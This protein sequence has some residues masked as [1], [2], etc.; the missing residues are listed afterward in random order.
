MADNIEFKVSSSKNTPIIIQEAGPLEVNVQSSPKEDVKMSKGEMKLQILS[1]VA[2]AKGDSMYDIAVKHGYT[3]TEEEFINEFMAGGSG[4][5]FYNLDNEHPITGG[6]YTLD[7]AVEV[8]SSD[9]SITDETKNGMI[10]TFWDGGEWKTYRYKLFYDPAQPS[11]FANVDNWEEFKGSGG[12]GEETGRIILRR[13]S[14]NMTTKVGSPVHIKF[15]YDHVT[16]TGEE[17]QSTGNAGIAKIIINR[18]GYTQTLNRTL[19]AGSHSDIDITRYMGIGVTSVRLQVTVDTGLAQ[20]SAAL[21]WT[22]SEVALNLTSDSLSGYT[23]VEQGTNLEVAYTLESGSADTKAVILYLDGVQYAQNTVATSVGSGLFNVD[24]TE[25]AHGQ[26][27]IQLRAQQATGE[28]DEYEQPVLLYSNLIYTVIGVYTQAGTTPL[29]TMKVDIADGSHVFGQ[30]EPLSLNLN[31]Y[32]TLTFSYG[33]RSY[34]NISTEV[35]IKEGEDTIA[36]ATNNRESVDYSVRVLTSGSHSYSVNAGETAQIAIGVTATEVDLGV[37]VPSGRTM[38]LDAI[39][40]GHSNTDANRNTWTNTEGGVQT[41]TVMTDFAWSGD[42]WI[43]GALRLKGDAR[44]EVSYRPLQATASGGMVCGFKYKCTDVEEGSEDEK[45]ISCLDSNGTGFF[46]TPNE[47]TIQQNGTVRT[48][49]K[50][51][52][53][54]VY[55]VA[56]VVWPASGSSSDARKNARFI[57]IFIDGISSGGYRLAEGSTMFQPTSVPISIGANGVTTDIYRLW[58]YSRALNDSEVL[59]TFILDQDDNIDK[60]LE[61]R[62]DNA[63][64][65]ATGNVTPD[66]LPDGIRVMIITGQAVEPS[67]GETMA[68]VLAAA[69]Y[70]DKST[71]FPAMEI[72]SYIKGASDRSK[73]FIARNNGTGQETG[74]NI[75]LRIRLQGTSS[76]AYPVKNYRIYT[77]KSEMYVGNNPDMPFGE[78][79]ELANKGLFA[80]HDTSAPVN[81]WC[82]KADYAESSGTHNTG[83]ARMVNDTFKAIGVLTPAQ[84]DVDDTEYPYDVRTTVDGEPCLLFYRETLTDTPI[85]LGKFNFNNDK[86]TEAVYG[87]T[88]INGYH[89]VAPLDDIDNQETEFVAQQYKTATGEDLEVDLTE[90][91]EFKNNEDPMGSFLDDDFTTTVT[92]P[93]S[94]DVTPRWLGTFEARYP[95]EDDLN[96]KFADVS[97]PIVPHYLSTLVSWVKSTRVLDTD[98]EQQAAAKL[99]KFRN[100]LNQYFDV[101]HLCSYFAFTQFMA[102]L[103]QMVKNMMMG[104]WYDKNATT[105][106]AMGKVRAY[107][108]FYDNDTILGLINNGRLLAP[109]DVQRDTVQLYDA[110]GNPVYFYAGHESVLWNNLVS[111]FSTEIR[112][113]YVKIRSFLTNAKIFEYFDRDQASM[114]CERIYNLDALNKYVAPTGMSESAV[115][116]YRDLMQGSRKSH[117]RYFV[118]KR[119]SLFDNAWRA[120]EYYSSANE[121]SFKGI[122]AGGSAITLT[123]RKDGNVEVQSD[124]SDDFVKNYVVSGNTPTT[125]GKLTP[126]AV[127]TIFHVYGMRQL[128]KLDLSAWDFD[129]LNLGNFQYLEEFVF[130]AKRAVMPTHSWRDTGGWIQSDGHSYIDTGVYL[131]NPRVVCKFEFHN[132]YENAARYPDIFGQGN[133]GNSNF[134]LYND[135]SSMNLRIN[136][137]SNIGMFRVTAGDIYEV[138]ASSRRII[139]NGVTAGTSPSTLIITDRTQKMKM[140][141][142]P[143]TG[144]STNSK[145]YYFKLYDG[146]TLVREMYPAVDENGVACMYDYVTESFFYKAGTGDF[147]VSDEVAPFVEADN[148][149]T[150]PYY[151]SGLILGN[152]MPRLKRFIAQNLAALPSAD[153]SGCPMIEEIDLSGSKAM[154]SVNIP[155][156]A[157]LTKYK[158]PTVGN[159]PDWRNSGG[160]IENQINASFIDINYIPNYKTKLRVKV[161]KCTSEN[162]NTIIASRTSRDVESLCLFKTGSGNYY[163]FYWGNSSQSKYFATVD[164]ML[165]TSMKTIEVVP[166]LNG[167]ASLLFD[168]INKGTQN[169]GTWNGTKSLNLFVWVNDTVFGTCQIYSLEIWDNGTLVREMYPAIDNNGV[170]CMYDYVTNQFFYNKGTGEFTVSQEVIATANFT[171][172]QLSLVGLPRLDEWDDEEETGLNYGVPSKIQSLTFRDCPN[173]NG[174]DLLTTI[175]SA[176]NTALS[177]VNVTLPSAISGPIDDL[178]TIANLWNQ[179]TGEAS[180]LKVYGSYTVTDESVTTAQCDEIGYDPNGAATQMSTKIYGLMVTIDQ[181][182][183]MRDCALQ[184]F[185]STKEGY[186]PWA[187]II[188][189]QAGYGTYIDSNDKTRGWYMTKQ[190]A[191]L[192]NGDTTI[193]R[194]KYAVTDNNQITGSSSTYY[195]YNYSFDEFRYFTS[196]VNL[197]GGSFRETNIL[198]IT[199]PQFLERIEG[200]LTFYVTRISNIVLPESLTF[201]GSYN[202]FDNRYLTNVTINSNVLTK[203]DDNCFSNCINLTTITLKNTT[204]PTLGNYVFSNCSSLAHIYVP[205]SAVATYQAASGW[206]A[207]ASIIEAIPSN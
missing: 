90:C 23:V 10:I 150:K 134:Q 204:P 18:A 169:S 88:G 185:D 177:T 194:G 77:N 73:N 173:I 129:Q 205:A 61:K 163:D 5:G 148:P 120:G 4:N 104:F 33:A 41:S 78:T 202:F 74:K 191:A 141:M 181:S 111:Q 92:D 8:V 101:E 1:S 203:I 139:V 98:T 13:E 31:Q 60:L 54:N 11:D 25:L 196:V 30:N 40:H 99:Q 155:V 45:I 115:A 176:H 63:I 190:E 19:T 124:V 105:S 71:Y 195:G 27:T 118:E 140:N 20:Q 186:N 3:G 206:S 158:L 160:Y 39:Q 182:T 70:N 108:I 42:G 50:T 62:D 109:Y 48:T 199:L 170:A 112:N 197:A 83:M 149:F 46:I 80:M 6:N 53:G 56:F 7:T 106:T 102:C 95:D 184:T 44:A 178:I 125:I 28:I 193:F 65:D 192:W 156:G 37:E 113:A 91:W 168:G 154:G 97:D 131:D 79:G 26:H 201:L 47:I 198:G 146:D 52:E 22:I 174:F 136:G 157:P 127:G 165:T 103:D 179:N 172:Y 14:D 75:P 123:I 159:H 132:D 119:L 36:T 17:Q 9:T 94:G 189:E 183:I 171:P 142:G 24:T 35:V 38:Y 87:F 128:T 55:D 69:K 29:L 126:S 100:E 117:R 153:L 16:G 43:N 64:L 130:G 116:P 2:G 175:A 121:I 58:A 180:N 164:E 32:E 84:R 133:G 59:D 34:D 96:D 167:N 67:S 143:T 57:Y 68:S 72:S 137:T 166:D 76:L 145:F 147:T 15:F 82:L 207:Y 12:G 188:L 86:S 49:M 110:Q 81:V 66:S 114:F 144:T 85:F 135:A 89:D 151:N 162:A 93:D 138:D 200:T 51:A 161:G 122:S 187:S 21:A 107:M 152:S